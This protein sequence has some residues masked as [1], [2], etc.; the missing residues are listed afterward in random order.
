[1]LPPPEENADDGSAV[2]TRRGRTEQSYLTEPRLCISPEP[3]SYELSDHNTT[4]VIGTVVILRTAQGMSLQKERPNVKRLAAGACQECGQCEN[5]VGTGISTKA[6]GNIWTKTYQH[7]TSPSRRRQIALSIHGSSCV[8]DSP[9]VD[10]RCSHFLQ[11]VTASPR[12]RYY[13]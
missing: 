4:E 13:G 10:R 6:L 9:R 3:S 1:M 5:G 12:T 2:R 11:P 8:R 7:Q